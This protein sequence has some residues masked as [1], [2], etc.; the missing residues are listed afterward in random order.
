MLGTGGA[1][2]SD[3]MVSAK[4]NNHDLKE[5]RK[6]VSPDI[7]YDQMDYQ[8]LELDRDYGRVAVTFENRGGFSI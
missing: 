3:H 1:N 6:N 5:M 4:N 8:T 2:V 7:Y